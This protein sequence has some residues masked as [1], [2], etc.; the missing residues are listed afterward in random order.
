MGITSEINFSAKS[1]RPTKINVVASRL[2]PN[3]SMESNTTFMKFAPDI[4]LSVCYN[5]RLIIQSNSFYLYQKLDLPYSNCS[6]QLS[7]KSSPGERL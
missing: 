4:G 2:N 1:Y 3:I 7:K 6:P 5:S